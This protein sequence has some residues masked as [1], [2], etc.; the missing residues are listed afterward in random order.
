MSSIAETLKSELLYV[1]RYSNGGVVI[2]NAGPPDFPAPARPENPLEIPESQPAPPGFIPMMAAIQDIV[3]E[4]QSVVRLYGAGD[5]TAENIVLSNLLVEIIRSFTGRDWNG[6]LLG[7]LLGDV[8]VEAPNY[9]DHPI[10]ISRSDGTSICTNCGQE[11]RR[12]PTATPTH[13]DAPHADD[14]HADAHTDT[15]SNLPQRG[16]FFEEVDR[17]MIDQ[18][19]D[20]LRR[21]HIKIEEP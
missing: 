11:V 21:G 10:R 4:A 16:Q 2:S 12:A 17:N 14:P 9:C 15:A 19:L 6:Q 7:E 13:A 3:N 8:R 18:L 5:A 20:M 1:K